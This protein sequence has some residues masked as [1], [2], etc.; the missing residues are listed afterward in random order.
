MS[1]FI[2]LFIVYT[3]LIQTFSNEPEA[4]VRSALCD[5]MLQVYCLSH[6]S[7]DEL[8]PFIISVCQS[9]SEA[10]TEGIYLLGEFCIEAEEVVSEN[11]ANIVGVISTH[12]SSDNYVLRVE[13]CLVRN[14]LISS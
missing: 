13:A 8:Y 1:L 2:F 3:F 9:G 5:V 10:A 12:L 6:Y 14:W 7:W 4:R 11:L